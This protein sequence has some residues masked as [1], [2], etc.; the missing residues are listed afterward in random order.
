MIQIMTKIWKKQKILLSIFFIYKIWNLKLN[1][2]QNLKKKTIIIILKI[3]ISLIRNKN[4]I[5]N[6]KQQFQ[7]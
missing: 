5:N 7:L 2:I 4:Q 1:K 3:K 6:N